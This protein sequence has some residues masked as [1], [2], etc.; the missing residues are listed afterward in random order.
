MGEQNLDIDVPFRHSLQAKLLLGLL[1]VLG[2]MLSTVLAV[3]YSRGYELLEVRE[4]ALSVSNTHRVA[5]QIAEQL[6]WAE[7]VATS[8]ANLGER[9]PHDEALWREIPPNMIDLAHQELIAGGGLWPEPN[10]FTPGVVRRS[11][12]WGRDSEGTLKYFDDYNDPATPS[13]HQE[14]WYVPAR[15]QQRDRCYWSRSYE[16]PH[17]KEPMVTCTV[18]MWQTKRFVGVSTLDLRLAGLQAFVDARG[19]ALQ[20][21]AFVVDRNG[22]FVTTPPAVNGAKANTAEGT[23]PQSLNSLVQRLPGFAETVRFLRGTTPSNNEPTAARLAQDIDEATGT[24]DADEA[25]RIAA[26]LLD[27]ESETPAVHQGRVE[28]DPF[29]GEAALVTTLR[30][31]DTHWQLVVVQPSRL[32]HEAVAA[33]MWQ[34]SWALGLVIVLVTGLAGWLLRRLLV[35]PIQRMSRAM[36]VAGVNGSGSPIPVHGRDELGLLASTFNKYSDQLARSHAELSASA[37][38]FRAITRLAHDAL[39]QVDDDGRIFSINQAGEKM[40]GYSEDALRGRRF[41]QLIPWEPS[42]ERGFVEIDTDDSRAAS[43]EIELTGHRHDG[44]AFPAEFSVSYWSGPDYGLHNIQVRDV[45]ERRRAEDQTLRLA[46]HDSLTELPN[47]ALFNDRLLQAV[48][49]SRREKSQ[50]GLLFLDLDHFKIANDSLGHGIGDVLLQKVATRLRQCVRKIDTIAR[51]G[52]DEFAIVLPKTDGAAAVAVVAQRILDSIEPVFEIEGNAIR[53]GVSIGITL[54]PGDDVDAD[55]LL[56]KA[57]LAMYCAKAEGRNTFR[58]FT[59]RLQDELVERRAL[60]IELA[61]ALESN[62]FVLHYQPILRVANH[63]LHCIEALVRW[64][65]PERGLV[66]P[67]HFIPAAEQNGLIVNLGHWVIEQSLRDLAEWDRAGLPAVKLAINLSPAQFCDPAL[68][69]RLQQALAASGV[70]PERIELELTETVLMKDID[71]AIVIMQSLRAVGVGLSI[72]DFGTGYSSLTY[73]QRFPVQTLKI[74][75]AFCRGVSHAPGTAS[76]CRSVIALGHNLGLHLVGEG[77]EEQDD[78]R[79]LLQHGCDFM[80]GYLFCRP[81]PMPSLHEWV[82]VWRPSE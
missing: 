25:L 43:R 9:L 12:F 58:F 53:I 6:A 51:L 3:F 18:A 28:S 8:L 37:E 73:L 30:L 11:F 20:G 74:D 62:E 78:Y 26:Q 63:Q 27:R 2:L 35:A 16:D 32:V 29:L 68:A 23:A 71:T 77:V 21:Y 17:T 10:E 82:R 41:R 48:E 47:R 55:Q 81:Q 45:T 60:Q 22:V 70:S 52:G 34:V 38:Q 40:F 50:M 4:R 61:R 15:H 13:Y 69:P 75:K 79:F 64:Q 7:G 44:S 67:D 54:C 39:I 33:A 19:R 46:T 76:I 65:H 59:S 42:S 1:L 49:L 36:V 80:Q 56:R 14:E 5:R 57:D 66:L 31:P 72:D 24:I